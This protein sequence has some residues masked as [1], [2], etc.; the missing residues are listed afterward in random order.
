MLET[1]RRDRCV[2]RDRDEMI[3]V[4][5]PLTTSGPGGDGAAAGLQAIN[6]KI[7]WRNIRR[8]FKES[9]HSKI[10]ACEGE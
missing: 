8:N 3:I 4:H 9:M 10:P 1:G 7:R 5:F 2:Q 6:W